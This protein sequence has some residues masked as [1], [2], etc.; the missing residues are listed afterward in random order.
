LW[1]RATGGTPPTTFSF[2]SLDV[3]EACP[4]QWQLIHS[5]YGDMPHFP[6]RPHPAAVEGEIVHLVLDL[7]FKGLALAGLPAIDSPA[8]RAQIAN[9]N[10]QR[11]VA[12]RVAAYYD[13]MAAHPRGGGWRLR[14]G[15]QQLVNRIIRLFR[16][17]G[18]VPPACG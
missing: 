16:A 18:R 8:F 3:I 17:E 1:N 14:V 11:V 4:L 10:V 7:L 15:T 13:R 2:S 9:I 6:A 12:E 5:A